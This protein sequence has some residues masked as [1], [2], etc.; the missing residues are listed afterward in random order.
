MDQIDLSQY[1]TVTDARDAIG[2]SQRAI[3]RVLDRAGRDEVTTKFLGRTLVLRSAL[4]KLAA[5]YYPFG[6]ENRERA[7]RQWGQAGGLAKAANLE[8]D[9]VP[10]E[11]KAPKARKAATRKK[12]G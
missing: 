3:W 5:A 4:P 8:W 9:F 12:L 10:P 1:M 7:A 2:C 11:P 6:S